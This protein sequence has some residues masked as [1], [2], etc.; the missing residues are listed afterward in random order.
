MNKLLL[1]ISL[2][3]LSLYSFSQVTYT[4][5]YYS[6]TAA[7]GALC[8]YSVGMPSDSANGKKRPL[9]CFEPGAGETGSGKTT[10]ANA[11][12][13]GYSKAVKNGTRSGGVKQSNGYADSIVYPIYMVAQQSIASPSNAV[14]TTRYRWRAVWAD[15]DNYIDYDQIHFGGISL[16]GRCDL[17]LLANVG[18]SAG[19]PYVFAHTPATFFLASPGGRT[20]N[21]TNNSF[22]LGEYVK[23]GGKVA[24]TTGTND[25][26]AVYKTGELVNYFNDS[27]ANSFVGRDWTSGDGIGGTG[28]CCWGPV[29]VKEWDFLGGIDIYEWQLK[30]TKAP[31]AVAQTIIN[32][33]GSSVTLNGVSN[34]WYKTVAWA[35]QSGGSATITSPNSDTTTVTGLTPG[36]YVF[37]LTVTNT[38]DSRTATHDVTVNVADCGYTE[39]TYSPIITATTNFSKQYLNIDRITFLNFKTFSLYSRIDAQ[40]AGA[41]SFSVTIPDRTESTLRGVGSG[42]IL[43]DNGTV[44]PIGCTATGTTM[45]CQ[46]EAVSGSQGTIHISGEYK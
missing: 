4:W 27:V 45:T 22:Y 38:G 32:T 6:K 24:M 43:Y 17:Y 13:Y 42:S 37:R 36:T 9:F 15:Y 25:P 21:I 23:K 2:N 3:L 41:S 34:G 31:K 44:K 7:D 29:W 33:T 19:D 12:L 40:S 39:D 5:R 8:Y 16:G 14:G 20:T 18:N 26:E 10:E 35:K 28:H 46:F 1:T 11:V 30:H